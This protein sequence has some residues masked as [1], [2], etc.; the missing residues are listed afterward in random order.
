M[1]SKPL[2]HT[3]SNALERSQS[4]TLEDQVYVTLYNN[5]QQKRPTSNLITVLIWLPYIYNYLCT[6]NTL[7]L[8]CFFVFC[9]I[10]SA[11]LP[12][13]PLII[14]TDNI[15][16]WCNTTFYTVIL[17]HSALFHHKY[18]SKALIR[19]IIFSYFWTLIFFAELSYCKFCILTLSVNLNLQQARGLYRLGLLYDPFI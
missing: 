15:I 13:P 14:M 19:I 18:I 4:L 6:F 11:S 5:G 7:R 10:L 2:C 8:W 16:S 1:K 9:F 12:T 3:Q 17:S